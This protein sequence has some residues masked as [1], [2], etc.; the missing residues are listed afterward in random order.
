MVGILHYRPCLWF[1]VDDLLPYFDDLLID[2]S[3]RCR[4]A[5]TADENQA[6][7]RGIYEEDKRVLPVVS[8]IVP[9][10]CEEARQG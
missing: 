9:R 5:R 4:H 10:H 7:L 3:L 2:E 6:R 8:E 1:L